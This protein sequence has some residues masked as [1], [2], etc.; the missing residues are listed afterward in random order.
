MRAMLLP[1][2]LAG[3]NQLYGLEPTSLA[4]M[5]ADGVID[6][7]DNCPL[8]PNRDQRDQDSDGVGDACDNCLLTQN[9]SQENEGDKDSV[10]DACDPHPATS[11][12]CLVLID[13]FDNPAVFDQYWEGVSKSGAP[14]NVH[15]DMGFVTITPNGS[16]DAGILARNL[17]GVFDAEMF[18]L[19]DLSSG[20]GEV[21]VMVGATG[22]NE[23]Y[24]CGVN[25]GTEA[26]GGLFGA[27]KAATSFQQPHVNDVY[28]IR[29]ALSDI[30][31]VPP[32]LYCRVDYGVA[33]QTLSPQVSRPL[34]PGR[35]GIAA[36]YDPIRVDAIALFQQVP[37]GRCP[38][39]IIH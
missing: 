11:D 22:S 16:D 8:V 26:V 15:A 1:L 27:F 21:R 38:T 20:T 4:D 13:S 24:Y 25:N 39:P 35:A 23:G 12:D 34:I 6:D 5:D 9:P 19:A 7:G 18:G 31:G 32:V 10:G 2:V 37:G 17:S 14:A 28:R 3:C 30:A 36:A 33:V 29:L